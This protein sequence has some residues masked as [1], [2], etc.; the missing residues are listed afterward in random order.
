MV[1]EQQQLGLA[2]TIRQQQKRAREKIGNLEANYSRAL[3]SEPLF[4]R[5]D[6]ATLHL[7]RGQAREMRLARPHHRRYAHS[8][9][10]QAYL[11]NLWH[12]FLSYALREKARNSAPR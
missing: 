1:E 6:L 8:F 7:D 4:I 12:L 3:R 2:R 9:A 5:H 10:C 11:P